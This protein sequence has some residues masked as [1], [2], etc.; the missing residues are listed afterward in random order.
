MPSY[1]VVVFFNVYLFHSC[2][3]IT[4]CNPPSSS[5]EWELTDMVVWVTGA[6]SGIGEELALQLSKLGGSLVLSARRAQELERVK[7]RCLGESILH[8]SP[9]CYK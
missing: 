2:S 7:R 3:S 4:Y 9:D 6:S 5:T 8:S 1:L